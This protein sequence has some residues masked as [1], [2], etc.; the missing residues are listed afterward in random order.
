M[1]IITQKE[2]ADK[3][4]DHPY[5]NNPDYHAAMSVVYISPD[6][7]LLIG[8]WH[9]PA[10]E[11]T[12]DYGLNVENIFLIEGSMTLEN[13]NGEVAV[14]HAGDLLQC[15]GQNES[16]QCVVHEYVKAL[17]IVYP[18]TEEDLAFVRKIEAENKPVCAAVLR[19]ILG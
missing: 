16:V 14:G 8:Y 1:R 10:G 15:G 11:I 5:A 7:K 18:Q 19:K 17:F 9:A 6:G 3:L 12:L 2:L 13:T 4:F